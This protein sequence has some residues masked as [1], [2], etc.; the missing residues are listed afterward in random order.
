[1]Q[2]TLSITGGLKGALEIMK[3][4]FEIITIQCIITFLFR[5]AYK[6]MD[7]GKRYS[8]YSFIFLFINYILYIQCSVF[9]LINADGTGGTDAYRYSL[10]FLSAKRNLI[11]HYTVNSQE[12]IY[13]F[14]NWLVHMFTE[15][16]RVTLFLFHSIAYCCTAYFI[17]NINVKKVNIITY[18]GTFLITANLFTMFN[19]LRNNIAVGIISVAVIQL[20]KH[21]WRSAAV[22]TILAMGFHLSAIICV[23]IFSAYW[24]LN[25]SRRNFNIN[26]NLL[27]IFLMVSTLFLLNIA[28][29]IIAKRY[30]DF[31][32]QNGRRLIAGRSY[33][34]IIALL[35]IAK[36]RKNK[37]FK[38]ESTILLF[39]LIC[40]VINLYY[41]IAYRMIYILLQIV[42]MYIMELTDGFSIQKSKYKVNELIL[43]G[44]SILYFCY[45]CYA[46]CISEYRSSLPY[47]NTLFQNCFGKQL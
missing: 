4:F 28:S 43:S 5:L 23:P 8:R 19:L 41:F 34:V 6:Y 46:I 1:M 7:Y 16:F 31:Y 44:F 17:L 2:R 11:E 3:G 20:K 30:Q 38:M 13:S 32:L 21:K 25:Q 9:R 26:R 24:I 14:I 36:V 42:Y 10:I 47:I 40:L 15:D 29:G 39:S 18:I 22:L 27:F 12:V 37:S 33:M 35:F 45:R